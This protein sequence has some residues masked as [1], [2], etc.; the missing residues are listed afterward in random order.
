MTDMRADVENVKQPDKKVQ[1]SSSLSACGDVETFI[2]L[3]AKAFADGLQ[4]GYE[5]AKYSAGSG[6]DH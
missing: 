4:K 3:M 2:A 5:T 6:N 1:L